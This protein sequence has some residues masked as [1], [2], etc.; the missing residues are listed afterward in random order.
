MTCVRPAY[1]DEAERALGSQCMGLEEGLAILAD[2]MQLPEEMMPKIKPNATARWAQLCN[3]YDDP[4]FN[5]SI[6]WEQL[7]DRL[8]EAPCMCRWLWLIRRIAAP[9]AIPTKRGLDA[10]LDP[11]GP[12][13]TARMP[14]TYDCPRD[15]KTNEFLCAA[16]NNVMHL[17]SMPGLRIATPAGPPR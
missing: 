8:E 12:P 17:Y 6:T 3:L 15:P 5:F 10:M 16:P 2:A 13:K 7:Q 9:H 11:L 1:S 4:S 14:H